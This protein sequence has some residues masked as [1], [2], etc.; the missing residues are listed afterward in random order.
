MK[1]FALAAAGAAMLFAG[2]AQA[3]DQVEYQI[4]FQSTW[5]A[6]SHPLEYPSNAHHS[7]IVGAAHS[8]GYRLFSDAAN[9]TPGLEALA[10]RGA[11]SPLDAEIN[12]AIAKGAAIALFESGPLFGPPGTLTATFTTDEAHPFVSA[13]AMIAPSP[14]WF[15]GIDNLPLKHDGE[16]VESVTLTLFA[17]DAGTDSG[18]TYA[19]A[20]EDTMPRQNVRLVAGPHF[21]DDGG[22]M[23]VGT[24]TVT[25]LHKQASN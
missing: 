11:H 20:D 21:F 3:A 1:T 13:V 22:L 9:A 23:P 6:E 25:R 5:T 17:W 24:A 12:Q 7:G 14:D 15:T 4:E 8:D 2:A 19:A 18:T 16:W 10:E